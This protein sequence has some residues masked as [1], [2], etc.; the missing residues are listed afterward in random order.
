V[1]ATH[2]QRRFHLS[3]LGLFAGVALL[4]AAVALFGLISYTASRR[5]GEIGLRMALG[6]S[7]K[8]I[9]R[10]IVGEGVVTAAWGVLIGITG[11]LMAG[12]VLRKMLFGVTEYDP[13]TLVA[14]PLLL[15]AVAISAS[16]FPAWR[17]SRVDASRA[18]RAE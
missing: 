17:A 4:L 18:L 15:F 7:A 16:A 10:L 12:R 14:V 1:A 3:L 13:F 11:A 8:D 5:R 2:S 6:A 9:L